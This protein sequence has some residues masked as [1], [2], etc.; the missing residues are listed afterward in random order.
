MIPLTACAPD[1][2]PAPADTYLF[3][4]AFYC[5]PSALIVIVEAD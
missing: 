1:C 3:E 5:L 2:R 4:Q